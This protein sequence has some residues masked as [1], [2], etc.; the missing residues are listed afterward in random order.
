MNFGKAIRI[1][2]LK[3]V[4]PSILILFHILKSYKLSPNVEHT[5]QCKKLGVK[6]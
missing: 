1:L 2:Q 4:V 6:K 3:Q 5:F